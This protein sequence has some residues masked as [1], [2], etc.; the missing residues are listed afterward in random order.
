M[1]FPAPPRPFLVPSRTPHHVSVTLSIPDLTLSH[2]PI[3]Q[4][5]STCHPTHSAPS[6]SRPCPGPSRPQNSLLPIAHFSL[7][8]C[9]IMACLPPSPRRALRLRQARTAPTCSPHPLHALALFDLRILVPF[10]CRLHT[11]P[12]LVTLDTTILSCNLLL[13]IL[14]DPA[15]CSPGLTAHVAPQ[16][17]VPEQQPPPGLTTH[18]APQQLVPEQQPAAMK[19]DVGGKPRKKFTIT[20]KIPE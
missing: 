6:C 4:A 18:V 19:Q 9:R 7:L 16:Q 3:L 11:R 5:P 15:A 2:G 10:S 17:L 12:D 13:F 20:W 14:P 8:G 1:P